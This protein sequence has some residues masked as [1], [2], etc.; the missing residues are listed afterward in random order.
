MYLKEIRTHGFKSFADK[1]SIEMNNG[2]TSW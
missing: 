2:I 1:I